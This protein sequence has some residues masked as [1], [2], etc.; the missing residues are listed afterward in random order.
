MGLRDGIDGSTRRDF[1]HRKWRHLGSDCSTSFP[2][3]YLAFFGFS[4][5]FPSLSVDCLAQDS[6]HIPPFRCLSFFRT[7]VTLAYLGI[8]EGR[9]HLAMALW[10]GLDGD[11][12][13]YA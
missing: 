7:R 4:H 1:L 9:T 2:F 12:G 6:P 3:T 11:L 5:S 8:W 13:T 10:G